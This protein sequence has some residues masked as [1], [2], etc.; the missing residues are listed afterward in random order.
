MKKQLFPILG[1]AG[2]ALASLSAQAAT[3]IFNYTDGDLILDFSH[4]GGANDVEIDIGSLSYWLGQSAGGSTVQVGNYSSL[5]SSASLTTDSLSFA[6]FGNQNAAS[7]SVAAN[8][9][10]LTGKQTGAGPNT[11][12]NDVTGSKQNGISTAVQGIVAGINS[13]SA[14]DTVSNPGDPNNTATSAI[15]PTGGA[16]AIDG[17]THL[18]T[19]FSGSAPSGY[20]NNTTPSGFS[21]SGGSIVSDLFEF[22]PLGTSHQ[23]VYQGYF[24]LNSNGVLDFTAVPEPSTYGLLAGAG[25]L[26]VSLRNQLRRKQA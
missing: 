18:G 25:L 6:V 17:Y 22:D 5:L 9:D 11:P 26:V 8:T 24:T 4:S 23:S 15:I 7:G 12:P 20:P 10:Y 16:Q 3:P 13:W 1:V 14:N 21:T 19:S 2:L